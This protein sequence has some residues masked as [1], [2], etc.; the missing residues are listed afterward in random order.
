[1]IFLSFFL[2]YLKIVVKFFSIELI[3]CFHF[4]ITFLKVLDIIFHFFLEAGIDLHAL[5][6]EFLNSP[7]KLFLGLPPVLCKGLLH[8]D[9]F[10]ETLI[11][12]CLCLLNIVF[13]LN[14]TK[15]LLK[16]KTFSGPIQVRAMTDLSRR[17]IDHAFL[18]RVT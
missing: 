12:L 14:I 2:E 4:F 9:M 7:F 18:I 17:S 5:D 10:L 6:S 1:M 11:Y 15:E 13:S 3:E 16:S 8:V